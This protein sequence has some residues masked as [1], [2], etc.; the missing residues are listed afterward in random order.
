MGMLL[1]FNNSEQITESVKKRKE[2]Q[3]IEMEVW[4]YKNKKFLQV[5]NQLFRYATAQRSAAQS[6]PSPAQASPRYSA[7][8]MNVAFRGFY[9]HSQR[10]SKGGH[11]DG[12]FK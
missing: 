9:T 10:Q 4:E 1:N 6:K 11:S 2:T 12:Q 3:D 8:K 5:F 7:N